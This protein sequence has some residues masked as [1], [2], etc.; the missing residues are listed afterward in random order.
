MIIRY[1]N[2]IKNKAILNGILELLTLCGNE[3]VPPLN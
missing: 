1:Y 3:F 2:Q